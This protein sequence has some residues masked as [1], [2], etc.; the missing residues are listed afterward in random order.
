MEKAAIAFA[1]Q[2]SKARH[3]RLN[4]SATNDGL[5]PPPKPEL[6]DADMVQVLTVR[7]QNIVDI[8]SVKTDH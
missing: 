5:R 1:N 4:N 3:E 7:S 2:V 6:P 8:A